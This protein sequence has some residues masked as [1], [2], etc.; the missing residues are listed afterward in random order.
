MKAGSF[1]VLMLAAAI[2]TPGQTQIRTAQV[3]GGTVEGVVA[4]GLST[5]LGIPFAAPPVGALRWKAPQPVKAWSGL[6]KADKFGAG[7]MQE[8]GLA[9]QMGFEGKLSEDCLFIDVWSPAKA[10]TEKL[11]VIV[12]IYGGG[13]NSG[14]TGVPLYNGA[15]MARQGVVIVSVSYRVGPFGFLSAPELTKESGSSGNYGMLDMIAG[16]KWVQANVAKFGGDPAKVTIMGHSAGAMAVSRLTASPLTKG[17]FRAAI[18]QSGANFTPQTSL[19]SAEQLGSSFLAGLGATDLNAARALSA[20]AIEAAADARGAPR[21]PLPLDG[22]VVT[23]EQVKLWQA[24]RFNDTPVLIG[25]TS[26][27]AVVFGPSKVTPAEFEKQ[28]RA[29]YGTRADA[30]LAAY[31]HGTDEEASRSNKYLRRDT[32]FGWNEWTWAKLQSAHG[33]GK[34]YAYYFDRRG[35]Q[36]PDGSG[37]GAEVSLVFGNPDARRGAWSDEDKALSRLIQGYWVNF[38]KTLDPNGAGLPRWP[39]FSGSD[40]QVMR[41]GTI[42]AAGGVPDLA[43][44]KALDGWYQDELARR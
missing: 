27:E 21:F 15:N 5:Y 18:A 43:M 31:P 40:P 19:A 36:S 8:P 1:A 32:S 20:E 7:C 41:L 3:T 11:P 25:H 17:L 30:I 24:G 12:W 4:D 6:R 37:H 22:H 42:N 26:D 23:G 14:M 13:F 2:A 33:K 16:L 38:A 39:A 35:P 28:I 9:K 29:S 34:A 44:M 10:P